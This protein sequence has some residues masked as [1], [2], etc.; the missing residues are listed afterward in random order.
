VAFL[1]HCFVFPNATI[2]NS[3]ASAQNYSL[4]EKIRLSFKNWILEAAVR[5]YAIVREKIQRLKI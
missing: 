2:T 5:D 4:A 1:S 3:A